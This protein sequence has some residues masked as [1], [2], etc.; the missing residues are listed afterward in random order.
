[1][2]PKLVVTKRKLPENAAS[3]EKEKA[4]TPDA[5]RCKSQLDV[6]KNVDKAIYDH[7]TSL[8]HNQI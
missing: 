3:L 7:F 6:K 5:N 8:S 1:M 4:E 2:E